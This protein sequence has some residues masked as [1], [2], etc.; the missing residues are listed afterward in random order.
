MRYLLPAA[1]ALFALVVGWT[2]ATRDEAP[3]AAAALPD[4]E[5]LH[6]EIR[7]YLLENPEILREMV[8][9]LEEREGAD[10]A[11]GDA[12]LVADNAAALFD[13]GFSHVSGNPEGS[14]TLVEFIDYQCG[15]C[16]RAHPEVQALLDSDGDIRRITK[17]MPIL[18]PGSELAARAA[19]AT[20]IAEG[21]E[22]YARLGDA[23]MTTEGAIN[24]IALDVAMMEADLDPDAIRA[25]MNDEEVTRRLAE[26]RALA[27]AMGISG[28]PTFVFE[29]RLVRGYLPLAEMEALVAELRA[30]G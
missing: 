26:T 27:Q 5:A 4:R 15:F 17:E 20:L 16:R 8:A 29:D 7:G 22:A 6:G 10:R 2:L 25:A 14:L 21:G 3:P 9:L 12:A 13:D 11:A 18:G 30:G 28:T 19:I 1:A 23:L 24:D